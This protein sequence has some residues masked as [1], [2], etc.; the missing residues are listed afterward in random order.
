MSDS[1]R[2]AV[3]GMNCGSCIAKVEGALRAVPQITSVNANLANGSVTVGGDGVLDGIVTQTLNCLGYAV[4]PW[5]NPVEAAASSTTATS[6]IWHRFLIAAVLTVPVFVLEMGGHVFPAFHH[7]IARTIGMQTSWMIQF[8]LATLVL[9]WPGADFYRKGIPSL[10]RGAPDMNALV[11]LGTAAAWSYSAVALFLPDLLPAADRTVYFEAAA[12]IVTLILLGRWLEARAKGQTGD[13]I[14]RL[15]GL[16]PETA[17]VVRDGQDVTVAIDDIQTGDLIRVRPGE[18]IAVDGVITE[19]TSWVD[20]SMITGEPI[21]VEKGLEASLIGGTINGNGAMVMRAAAV[22]SDTMLARIIDMVETAQASRL[23]VQ[24]LVNKITGLFVPA[25]LGLA[26]LT[27]LG[28]LIFGGDAGLSK[29]LVAGVSVLIIACPCAMGLAVPVSI[30]VGTGRAAEMGVLF[31]QGAALQALGDIKTIAFDK[32]GTLTKGQPALTDVFAVDGDQDKLLQ[33]VAAVEAQSE[34]PLAAPIIAATNSTIL[35]AVKGFSAITGQGLRAQVAGQ[36]V[37]IGNDRLMADEGINIDAVSTH[38]EA[39]GAQAKTVILVAIGGK[40]AG[41]LAL[42]DTVFDSAQSVIST[43]MSDRVQPVLITGDTKQTAQAIADTLGINMVHAQT[44]PADK[45]AIVERLRSTTRT[46]F[47]GDGINDAPALAMADVGI[48]MGGGT[49]VAMQSADV[50]LM[51]SDPSA[52]LDARTISRATMRNI[53]QN[54]GWAFGYN[55]LLIPV[56]ALGLLSPGLA[57]GAMAL[58]SVLVVG[59][60]LRLRGVSR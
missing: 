51:R 14:R 40:A 6:A 33:I 18:R 34:H 4:S 52:I 21:A 32:T 55:V 56:A 44:L 42:S 49:D 39:L 23:P 58:S 16:R 45:A 7:L 15:I 9:A 5:T 30:M 48:A 36:L 54:L 11:V 57:A 22:G 27:V 38:F 46:A 28:W 20:E 1:K 26:L 19:G 47:V 60:A 37:L 41:L 10:I 8:T 3:S 25:V 29:A 24:D 17:T 35:P 31:R 50:V 43:L 2:Y 53:R 12:V 13:A 59:N